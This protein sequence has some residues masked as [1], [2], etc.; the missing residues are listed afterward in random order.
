MTFPFLFGY[1]FCGG[2][3]LEE[4]ALLGVVIGTIQ[5][6]HSIHIAS[7]KPWSTSNSAEQRGA[8]ESRF[9]CSLR[10]FESSDWFA[11]S[12]S[13]DGALG[14]RGVRLWRASVARALIYRYV[15]EGE[16]R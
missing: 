13:T 9:P 11:R 1:R 2:A 10:L 4:Q 8:A 16:R 15:V 5:K 3:T 7:F 6:V 14:E 12:K